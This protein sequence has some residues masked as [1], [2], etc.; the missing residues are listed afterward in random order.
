MKPTELAHEAREFSKAGEM[1]KPLNSMMASR[2]TSS[3]LSS[4]AS[5]SCR[6]TGDGNS[7]KTVERVYGKLTRRIEEWVPCRV[8]KTKPP[9]QDIY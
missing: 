8:S 3:S 9:R 2:F 6:D 4:A 7:S 1:Y 5:T